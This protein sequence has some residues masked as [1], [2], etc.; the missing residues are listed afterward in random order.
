MDHRAVEDVLRRV[1]DR[2]ALDRAPS[3]ARRSRRARARATI[4]VPSDVQR[5]PAVPKP[6][7]SAPSTARSRS[8][9]AMTTSGFLPPSSRHGDCRW[10]PQSAPISAPDRARA[11]EADLVDEAARRAPARGPAKVCGPSASTRFSTPSGRPACRKSW[12]SASAVAGA[13]SAGFHTTALPHSSAGTRYQDGTATGKLPAVMIA[14][15]PTGDA[16]GEQLLVGHLRRHGLAVEPPA[17][18]DEEVA[19][20]DDLLDL[21][22]RLGVGLADLARD[23]ARERLLVVLHEPAE[24]LDRAAAHG[25][26]HRGPLALRRARGLAGGDE[27]AGVAEQRRRRRSRRCRRGWWRSHGRRARR[28]R[29]RPAMIEATVR[30]MA[31]NLARVRPIAPEREAQGPG[32]SAADA[33]HM[34]RRLSL[35]PPPA[36]RP[37]CSSPAAAQAATP[38]V[39]IAGVPDAAELDQAQRPRRQVR[40]RLRA[41]AHQPAR[42]TPTFQASSRARPRRGH[43]GRLRPHRQRPTAPTRRRRPDRLRQRRARLRRPRCSRPA[44]SPPTR[45]GTRRTRPTSGARAVDAGALRRDPQGRLPGDQA[46][47]SG[48]QGAARAADGQQLQLPRAGLRRRRRRL[49]RRRRGPHRHRLPRRPARAPSTART[50]RSRASPSWASAPCT[51]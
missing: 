26:G 5:W 12:A 2:G 11:G 4:T 3:G 50:A 40:A 48:R 32:R 6:L 15:T 47:R 13:Y 29:G 16:E 38:G 36:R 25:R 42:P 22:E 8:A 18:A 49:V 37:R 34:M 27:G 46:G 35:V 14:A 20:V 30:D 28:L 24:L 1:A 21:A 23:Q 17:L 7:N 44:A 51:T 45:S 33:A 19:G 43:E 10:R 39:N 41:A 31:L 9:S